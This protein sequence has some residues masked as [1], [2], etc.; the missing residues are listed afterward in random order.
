L[1][2]IEVIL[3]GQI[4]IN[5][6]SNEETRKLFRHA[7]YLDQDL[8]KKNLR[9]REV[10]N[11]IFNAYANALDSLLYH[12]LSKPFLDKIHEEYGKDFCD[13]N[14]STRRKMDLAI[15]HLFKGDHLT[16]PQWKILLNK[17][18]KEKVPKKLKEFS[19]CLPD[20]NEEEFELLFT[21][22]DLLNDYRIPSV[23]GQI[24][25][26]EEYHEEKYKFI[27]N[28]NDIIDFLREF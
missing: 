28:L 16:L 12:S 17:L 18:R 2:L 6:I 10:A 11:S 8:Y 19:D 14:H 13:C 26:F 20:L 22:I 5:L 27:H 23:H 4:S 3:T 24:T 1:L 25:T 15:K 7:Y 21:T 9:I